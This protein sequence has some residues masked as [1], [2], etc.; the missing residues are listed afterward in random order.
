MLDIIKPLN[1]LSKTRKIFHSEADFQFALAWEI[2]KMY[3]S[4]KVRMEYCPA[5][6]DASIHIDILVV[7]DGNWYPIE[8]KYK[9]LKCDKVFNDEKFMLKNHGA[10]DL[11]RYDYIKDVSRIERLS[12]GLSNFKKGFAVLLTNDPSY[13]NNTD[14]SKTVYFD[15]RLSERLIE[16]GILK[17]AVHAGKGTTKGREKPIAL[18]GEYQIQWEQFSKLDSDRSGTFKYLVIT[19]EIN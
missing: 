13:W 4:A 16:S 5:E 1:E 3:P 8:L 2:H 12:K 9:S 7:I 19:K 15:F 6:I 17:W 14:S 10:Q 11:G 18:E